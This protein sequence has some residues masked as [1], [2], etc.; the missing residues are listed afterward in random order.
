VGERSSLKFEISNPGAAG[1]RGKWQ[2]KGR[3]QVAFLYEICE[4]Q[5]SKDIKKLLK[6]I[7]E[8]F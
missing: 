1:A 2:G 7:P 4:T 3:G 5:L 6:T 8:D